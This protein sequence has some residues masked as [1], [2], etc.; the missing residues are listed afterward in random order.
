MIAGPTSGHGVST[1][2]SGWTEFGPPLLGP[3]RSYG[4][5]WTAGRMPCTQ[6][7]IQRQALGSASCCVIV[8]SAVAGGEGKHTLARS[9]KAGRRVG[10]E[11]RACGGLERFTA[12]NGRLGTSA[13]AGTDTENAKR[14]RHRSL[15]N[16]GI[17]ASGAL[18]VSRET[19]ALTQRQ[20][21]AELAAS[22]MYEQASNGTRSARRSLRF[23]ACLPHLAC[24][25]PINA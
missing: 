13:E 8:P 3:R 11:M 25:T 14:Q 2:L 24:V 15:A 23:P 21:S 20:C 4:V 9:G 1:A 7:T 19:G 22:C 17:Q 18:L 12:Q 5:Q 16:S 10:E 6:R